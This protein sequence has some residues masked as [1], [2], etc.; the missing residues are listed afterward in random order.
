MS[1][2]TMPSTVRR[3]TLG[4]MVPLRES[5]SAPS[6]QS[7]ISADNAAVADMLREAAELLAT[8]GANPFRV[9]AYRKASDTVAGLTDS[10]V[11]SLFEREGREG[12]D[13]LP[14]VG[15]GIASTIAEILITGHWAQLDRLRG[16]VNPVQLFRTI[17][18]VGSQS[19]ERIHDQL[20][21]DTLEALEVAALRG[22]LQQVPGIGP[23]RAAAIRAALTQLLDRTRVLRSSQYR[24]ASTSAPTIDLLLQVDQEYRSEADVGMLPAI[25]PRR[26]N[27]SGQKTLAIRGREDECRA[28]YASRHLAAAG[29]STFSKPAA[30]PDALNGLVD[31]ALD[32]RSTWCRIADEPWRLIDRQRWASTPQSVADL[33]IGIRAASGGSGH[34]DNTA[35][36]RR[37]I[38]YHR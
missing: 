32:L 8:Q 4:V 28:F 22:Q 23:R 38:R 10:S 5:R 20:G 9:A 6:R 12:L 17:P 33:A 30:L 29:M 7:P 2:A 19:A 3:D 18:G 34:H 14:A 36:N 16:E 1:T 21:V 37:S 31:L 35:G 11:R 15:K 13:K 26:F 25:A 24:T 27:P